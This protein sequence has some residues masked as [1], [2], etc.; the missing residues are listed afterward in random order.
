MFIQIYHPSNVI[1]VCITLGSH[2]ELSNI[3]VNMSGI[4]SV[5]SIQEFVP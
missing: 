4:V 3:V 5:H 1:N 2:Q